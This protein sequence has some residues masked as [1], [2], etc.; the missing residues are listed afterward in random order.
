MTD[1]DNEFER[2]VIAGLA[3][4]GG[5]TISEIALNLG[6]QPSRAKSYGAI[7]IRRLLEHLQPDRSLRAYETRGIQPKTVRKPRDGR[8]YES[9]SFPAFDLEELPKEDWGR[10]ALRTH[11]GRLLIVVLYAP[12]KDTPMSAAK[13]G[14]SF[15][16]SPSEQD[17]ARIRSEW[18]MF[19]E[20]IAAGQTLR[21]P[22]E[23]TT[24]VIH[25]RTHGRDSHDVASAPMVGKVP[26]RSFW[27]NKEFVA[28]LIREHV[29]AQA[30]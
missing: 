6:V 28:R 13:L 8:P 5:R 17:L 2:K 7:V 25:V 1:I 24:A 19:R 12:E 18:E 14:T 16:W 26:K 30:R 23:A 11:L 9:M 15:F 3:A 4:F 27:L 10:S 29:R 20:R 22:G 21:L